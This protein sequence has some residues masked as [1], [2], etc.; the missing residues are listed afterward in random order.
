MPIT[1]STLAADLKS[2][3]DQWT[4]REKQ[5]VDWLSGTVTGG[6]NGTGEYP[7]TDALGYLKVVPCP[8]KIS[9]MV[10]DLTDGAAAYATAASASASSSLSSELVAVDKAAAAMVSA[11][12]ALMY[13]SN[14]TTAKTFAQNHEANCQYIF[15]DFNAWYLGAFASA[16]T[17]DNK[18]LSLREGALYFNTTDTASYVRSAGTW[19]LYTTTNISNWDSAYSWGNHSAAGYVVLAGQSG[20]QILNG[21]TASGDG[22]TLSTTAHATKGKIRFG[23]SL[24]DEATN[25]LAINATIVSG[26]YT[27]ANDL[28]VY[29]STINY[30]PLKYN[31]TNGQLLLGQNATAFGTQPG[32]YM[33]SGVFAFTTTPSLLG[34][35]A[36]VINNFGNYHA[37]L[38]KKGSPTG[39]GNYL[40]CQT[41]TAEELFVLRSGGDF[42]LSGNAAKQIYADRNT[43]ANTAGNALTVQA[44]GA[45]VGAT[46]KTGGTL[47]LNGGIATGTGFSG[48][49]IK[50]AQAG[51]TGTADRT[52]ATIIEALGNK[53]AFNGATPVI[54]PTVT[55]SRT[56]G[57]ALTSLLTALA[58][59]GLI[60]D[61][62]T[63]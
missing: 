55:G 31:A 1:N 58:A 32:F 23:G 62:T 61:S 35:N 50:T 41:S 8:A 22:L 34:S 26:G 51:A 24:Y 14:A 15:D 56:D 3:V 47:V 10:Q 52:P 7:L 43:V 21:G 63:A 54:K 59:L 6:P 12:E 39:V 13:S 33:N 4:L 5:M 44:G 53:L 18:G 57:T 60:T 30:R 2:M 49:Q 46:D 45:T 27:P 19:A 20:G 28:E 48:V 40:V 25:R 11:S 36:N 38:V 37:L 9:A 16:P 42:S 29:S 17:V